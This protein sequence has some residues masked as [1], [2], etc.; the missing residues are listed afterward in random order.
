MQRGKTHWDSKN[1]FRH[2]LSIEPDDMPPFPGLKVA[3]PRG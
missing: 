1:R 2:R 3:G